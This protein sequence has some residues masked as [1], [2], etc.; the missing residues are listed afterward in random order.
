MV[1]AFRTVQGVSALKDVALP[2]LPRWCSHELAS[3]YLAD[4]FDVGRLYALSVDG[5]GNASGDACRNICAASHEN[6]FRAAAFGTGSV[7]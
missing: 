5:S 4:L 7:E 2:T 1:N 3:R 6:L